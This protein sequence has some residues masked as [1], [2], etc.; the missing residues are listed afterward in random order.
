MNAKPPVKPARTPPE[1]VCRVPSALTGVFA[2][3]IALQG[4][5]LPL[6]R[7]SGKNEA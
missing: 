5:Y 6:R 3:F 2:A 4:A 1:D 7:Y